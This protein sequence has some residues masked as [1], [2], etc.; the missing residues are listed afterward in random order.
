MLE[1]TKY[2]CLL[3]FYRLNCQCVDFFFS[4]IH[5]HFNFFLSSGLRYESRSDIDLLK[6]FKLFP[7]FFLILLFR[8]ILYLLNCNAVLPLNLLL[9]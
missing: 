9:R 2:I 4:F 3:K 7:D 5:Y 6:L 8:V 1:T